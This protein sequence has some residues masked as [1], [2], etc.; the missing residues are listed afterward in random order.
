MLSASNHVEGKNYQAFLWPP[1]C[2]QELSGI[3]MAS[4]FFFFFSVA[5]A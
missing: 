5:S 3:F 4:F 2:G 1:C